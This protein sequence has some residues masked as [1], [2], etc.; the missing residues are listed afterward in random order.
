MPRIIQ[1]RNP[2][3]PIPTMLET[4]VPEGFHTDQFVP[5][6]FEGIE[7]TVS[8]NNRASPFGGLLHANDIAVF[9]PKLYGSLVVGIIVALIIAAA[10]YFFVS[11]SI[12]TNQ[13]LPETDPV[14]SFKGQQNQIKEGDAIEKFYG[15][16]RHWPS[17]ASRP[18]NQIISGEQWY[19]GLFVCSI[20]PTEV[21][22]VMV[23]DTLLDTFPGAE[24][25]VCQPGES[26]T[27]FPTNVHTA[28]EI[29]NIELVAPNEDEHDWSGGY[30]VVPSG[31]T[32]YRIEIDLSF[33]GGLY[34]TN[35]SGGLVS[36]TVNAT[37]EKRLIDDAGAPIGPWE[38]ATNFSKT[39]ATT[40]SERFT[41]G[42]PVDSGR[43]EIRGKRTTNK[44]D[45][46]KVRDALTW[47]S[48]RAYVETNQNFGNVTLLAVKLRASNSLNDNSRSTFNVKLKGTAWIYST[49]TESWYIGHTRSPIWAACDVLL[50]SYGRNLA[51]KFINAEEVAALAAKKEEEGV[52]YDGAIDQQSTCWDVIKTILLSSKCRPDLPGTQFSIV[53][54]APASFPTLCLNCY[55]IVRDSVKITHEFPKEGAKDGLEVEYTDPISWKSK[56]VLCLIGKDK[57]LNPERVRLPGCTDRNKAYQWGLYTRATKTWGSTNVSLSTGLE[58]ETIRFGSFVAVQHD[59]LPGD[60]LSNPEHTGEVAGSLYVEGGK[61]IVPVPFNFEFEDGKDYRMSVRNR[62]GEMI[63]PFLCTKGEGLSVEI[64]SE[65][66]VASINTVEGE[67]PPTYFFGET[68]K[69]VSFFK[70]IKIEPGQ[71]DVVNLTLTP[72]DERLYEFGEEVA[73]PEND[74]F[75]VVTELPFPVVSGLTGSSLPETFSEILLSWNPAIGAIDYIIQ[76]SL[77]NATWT[78]VARATATSYRL[79]VS[80]GHIYVRV[81]GASSGV[82]PWATWDGDVGVPST[83]P[84]QGT[85][86]YISEP[87]TGSTVYL[88]CAGIPLATSYKWRI[89]VGAT[90]LPTTYTT[91]ESE[92]AITVSA[93]KAQ[94]ASHAQP[95]SREIYVSVAGD[96]SVGTGSYSDDL[97]ASNELPTPASNLDASFIEVSSGTN[98]LNLFWSASEDLDLE[99]YEVHLAQSTVDFAISPSTLKGRTTNISLQATVPEDFDPGATEYRWVVA[100]KDK[101]GDELVLSAY[102]SFYV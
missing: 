93:L 100:S 89:K 87:F 48:A 40:Q 77:D 10:I 68:G 36:V 34:S 88:S 47:E 23:D 76:T 43:Y 29:A 20:G 54:D 28:T 16:G 99:Y 8:I 84:Y 60:G 96:N 72:Y 50:A 61:T 13:G 101:W 62:K 25:Q 66:D 85:T 65:L 18:Y 70:I 1:V 26:V 59:L 81:A 92:F 94:A 52:Y 56:T 86:P 45:D 15:E 42:I 78:H 91:T 69:D 32:A 27:L 58:G 49:E 102:H 44:S 11:V 38:L 79:P 31:D 2:L 22:E 75:S 12:P 63:G 82:G 5:E 33:R 7:F 90:G 19:F 64:A 57:G 53:E 71:G 41:V 80:E 35:N 73:P 55:N 21:E 9:V 97:V 51:Q 24:Y 14:Y 98:K 6:G 30:S 74:S 17:Y 37:F 3:N 46:F 39:M 83:A 95:F 4:F 67:N